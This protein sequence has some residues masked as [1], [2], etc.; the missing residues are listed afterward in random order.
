MKLITEEIESVEVITE[1]VN[2]NIWGEGLWNSLPKSNQE[3]FL[4][5]E[6]FVEVWVT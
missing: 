5:G 3:I 4:P 6:Y 1:T 2:G